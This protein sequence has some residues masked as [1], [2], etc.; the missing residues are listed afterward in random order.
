MQLF[1]DI[2][3]IFILVYNGCRDVVKNF[4]LDCNDCNDVF[5]G[6]VQ[7]FWIILEN[8]VCVTEDEF[9]EAIAS[10]VFSVEDG[11]PDSVFVE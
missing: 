4:I 7:F 9:E 2:V 3:K 5:L 6:L 1:L 8:L 10:V 11:R